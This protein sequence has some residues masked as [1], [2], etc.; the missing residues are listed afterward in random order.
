MVGDLTL[1]NLQYSHAKTQRPPMACVQNKRAQ[2]SASWRS[3]G[4]LQRQIT[5]GRSRLRPA[6]ANQPLGRLRPATSVEGSLDRGVGLEAEAEATDAREELGEGEAWRRL[7]W[8]IRPSCPVKTKLFQGL[9]LK[10]RATAS[11]ARQTSCLG[12]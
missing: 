6:S 9:V 5:A 4:F 2:A 10:V 11:T 1:A 8:V 12:L 3:G 7:T